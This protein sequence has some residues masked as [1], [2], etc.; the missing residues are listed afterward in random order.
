VLAAHRDVRECVVVAV[1]GGDG[2]EL[3]AYVVATATADVLHEHLSEALPP[4]LLPSGYVFLDA[5]P[6][7]GNGKVARSRLA[8][9]P[10]RPTD[11]KRFVTPVGETE[12]RIAA[13]W[14]DLLGSARVGALDDFFAH[15][16]HSLAAARLLARIRKEFGVPIALRALFDD[17]TVRGLAALVE[18]AG[19]PDA[20][21][22]PGA[23]GP[24]RGPLSLAQEGIWSEAVTR[25]DDTGLN[26]CAGYR[27]RGPL[28]PDDLMEAVAEVI[29]RHDLLRATVTESDGEPSWDYSPVDAAPVQH[30]DLTGYPDAE[31]RAQVILDAEAIRPF[32]LA[33]G[34]LIRPWLLR[35]G[36]HDHILI[37]AIHHLVV[38][39]GSMGVLMQ[40][41]AGCYAKGPGTQRPQVR[42]A[43]FVAW[44]RAR[45]RPAERE[46][47]ADYWTAALA[48]APS[49][50]IWPSD[51]RP[52]DARRVTS[53]YEVLLPAGLQQQL[54]RLSQDNAVSLFTTMLTGFGV[55]LHRE[56]AQDDI[57]IATSVELRTPETEN[58]V[59]LMVNLVAL[60]LRLE[61]RPTAGELLARMHHQVAGAHRNPDLPLAILVERL[62]PKR[63]R[64]GRS[65]LT[66]VSF[67]FHREPEPMPVLAG[68]Q[69][70]P[71]A[72]HRADAVADLLLAVECVPDGMV[73]RF[74][75]DPAALTQDAVVRFGDR[76]GRLLAAM[77][78]APDTPVG[79]LPI[80]TAAEREQLLRWSGG[81]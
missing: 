67:A 37:L 7:T 1:P 72:A 32:D 64:L 36:E 77:A 29:R 38:D 76:L 78:A 16:G 30:V 6:V 59:G 42:Y 45:L 22:L 57:I 25:P 55:L 10:V 11:R 23:A 62:R 31:A 20:V 69:A 46:R 21:V 34:P 14:G 39:G 49:P 8:G 3:I 13:L 47:Q 19:A 60:R 75:F 17:P 53:R 81:G 28:R 79:Q 4:Q 71:I 58:V 48:A 73:A 40:D 18:A 63:S 24:G 12:S 33:G 52:A 44:Q 66:Q 56:T 43:D 35:L 9:Q 74:T 80:T 2:A 51:P 68:V 70:E 27:L 61:D 50:L 54:E 41:L 5:L 65:A 26:T 15:G